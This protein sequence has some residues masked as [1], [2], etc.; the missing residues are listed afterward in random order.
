MKEK[1]AFG[2]GCFWHV[3]LEFSKLKDVKTEVGYIGGLTKE[4]SYEE[5]CTDKTGHAEVVQVVFDPEK[6]SYEKLLEVFWRI[7]DPTQ[8][9]RQGPDIGTQYRSAIFYYNEKQ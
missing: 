6:T 8:I 3:E 9:N 2:A 7:H 5:V 4:P 1:I